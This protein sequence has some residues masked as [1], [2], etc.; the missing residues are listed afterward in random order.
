VGL[1]T[2]F[3]SLLRRFTTYNGGRDISFTV[4][5]SSSVIPVKTGM[6]EKLDCHAERVSS[7]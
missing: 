3:I 1:K 6:T 4:H 5:V 7:Q 2:A